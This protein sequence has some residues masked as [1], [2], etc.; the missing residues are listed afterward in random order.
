[1]KKW[2]KIKAIDKETLTNWQLTELKNFLSREV[3]ERHP[4]YSRLFKETGFC[5]AEMK[6]LSDLQ[7]LPFTQLSDLAIK[8]P[9]DNRLQRFALA[10]PAEETVKKA[11]PAKKSFFGKLFQKKSDDS[12]GDSRD[13]RLSQVFYIGDFT[14][15]PTPMVITTYDTERIKEAGRRLFALWKLERDDTM[16]N[17]LSYGPNMAFWQV[18][19]AGLD[20]GSTVLQSGGGRILG[21]EKILTALEN[22]EAEVL[23][24]SPL[25][26]CNLL[27]AAIKF[28]VNIKNLTTIVLGLESPSREM[29]SRLKELMSLAGTAGT[30]VIRSFFLTEAKTGW[31]ECP[32]GDGYHFHPDLHHI[33]IIDPISGKNLPENEGG[34][35]VLTHLDARGT[36]LI[37]YRTGLL[38][39]EGL[40]FS[41]CSACGSSLPRLA[42]EIESDKSIIKLRIGKEQEKIINLEKLTRRLDKEKNLL[43]WQGAIKNDGNPSLTIY[44]SWLN[45]DAT[46]AS[47]LT[48]EISGDTGLKVSF[49]QESYGSVMDKLKLE[50]AFVA[51][52]WAIETS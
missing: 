47:S 14:S 37:R 12:T 29:V 9:Q 25:Y 44:S 18:F 22:M 50:T 5:P 27:Q 13:Y 34:E 10:S 17:A 4:Y 8:K 41:P 19:Y 23:F 48:E 52:R 21:A 15:P 2:D 38:I 40:T 32:E 30:R 35:I 39:T 33:E 49:V 36:C 45:K 43:L 1:M 16:V 3:M 7:A 51:Q 6:S 11:P 42:G 26:A 31:G 46:R 24:A 28:K 20:L